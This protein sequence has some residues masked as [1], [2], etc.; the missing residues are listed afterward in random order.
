MA[1]S[2]DWSPLSW[3]NRPVAQE[4]TYSDPTLLDRACQYLASLPP[5]IS[6][7]E[8]EDLRLSMALASNGQAFII[9]AGDCAEA[10]NDVQVD[11]VHSKRALIREQAGMLERALAIPVVQIGRIAGQYAKPRTICKESLPCGSV[12]DTFRGD[13]I[14]HPLGKET[15]APNPERLILGHYLAAAILS[16]L[17]ISNGSNVDKRSRKT[18]MFTSHEA[19]HLP[20]ESALTKGAYN[21]SAHM[22]WIGERT[23]DIAGAH[24]EYV[25]GLRNPIGIKL[26]PTTDPSDL[27]QLLWTIDAEKV[28]GRVT[29]ITRLG[30]PM[31]CHVLPPLIQ[32][33]QQA[34]FKPIWLCD[35]CHG[36][37]FA[38][39]SGIKT[40]FVETIIAEVKATHVVHR[41]CHSRLGGLHL[42]QTGEDITECVEWDGG[43][44]KF[45]FPNYRSLCDPRLSRTQALRVVE[46]YASFVKATSP[47]WQTA[48]T[49]R[50]FEGDKSLERHHH[51]EAVDNMVVVEA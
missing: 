27:V 22:L 32:A 47:D 39:A 49:D 12:V 29:L 4:I 34:G 6:N 36:N 7:V 40:R 25:R 16:M 13:N 23:R 5:L 24:L 33:V 26:G 41:S 11:I 42:E 14:N 44:D 10:F 17:R 18:A 37:T 51:P 35:P 31:V 43:V 20:L 15:R 38:T 2:T 9:Q 46:E 8:I 1:P 45:Q 3:C 28:P 21:T 30:A 50:V 48:V 19:L